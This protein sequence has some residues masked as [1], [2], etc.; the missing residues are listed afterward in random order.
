MKSA[1]YQKLYARSRLNRV[2]RSRGLSGY[3]KHRRPF[4]GRGAYDRNPSET[5]HSTVGGC[6]KCRKGAKRAVLLP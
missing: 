2:I 4:D 5:C 6:L 3:F 1:G